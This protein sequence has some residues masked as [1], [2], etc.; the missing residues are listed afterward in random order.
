MEAELVSA[1]ERIHDKLESNKN[2]LNGKIER[3]NADVIQLQTR[4]DMTPEVKQ[5]CVWFDEHK[6]N[7][8]NHI[9]DHEKIRFIWVKAIIGS[10]VSAIAAAIGTILF[11]GHHKGGQ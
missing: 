4:F 6:K 8:D 11:W 7:F 9:D 10:V 2:H 5:P 3:L 1:F